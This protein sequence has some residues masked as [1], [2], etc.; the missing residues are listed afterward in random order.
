MESEEVFF[1]IKAGGDYIRVIPSKLSYKN[2]DNPW[3]RNWLTAEVK[4]KAG[5]FFGQYEAQFMTVDFR[6]FKKRLEYLYDHLE[7]SAI[8]EDL[9]QYLKINIKG[10]GLGHLEVFCEASDNP[11]Y[12]ARHIMF[13]LSID[14]TYIPQLI[15]QLKEIDHEFP[16]IDI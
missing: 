16:V 3:D 6:E 8:F 14:Q 5:A 2:C 11:G 9:E 15:S 4:V 12:M 7:S 1:E 10:D 13:Y